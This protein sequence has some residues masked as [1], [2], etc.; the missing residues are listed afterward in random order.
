MR[1]KREAKQN[2]NFIEVLSHV[3][4]AHFR[5]RKIEMVFFRTF[6]K[7]PYVFFGIHFIRQQ[8]ALFIS[9]D[10]WSYLCFPSVCCT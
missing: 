8:M 3:K 5:C 9:R 7:I 10:E 2:L 1:F 6:Q 4:L